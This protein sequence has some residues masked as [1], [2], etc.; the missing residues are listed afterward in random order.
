MGIR[1][2]SFLKIDAQGADL[3]VIRSAGARLS[4]IRR[5][6]L[7]VQIAD[8]ALYAGG[9]EKKAT[10][11]YLQNSGFRLVSTEKQSYGQEESLTF[12]RL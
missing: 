7:E 6:S 3:S 9:S 5:I 8:N 1:E 12:E 2:V 4:T 11:D 10:V